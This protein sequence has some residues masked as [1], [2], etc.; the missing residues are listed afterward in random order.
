M[1]VPALVSLGDQDGL[2]H[3]RDASEARCS[4]WPWWPSDLSSANKHQSHP[5][6]VVDLCAH[7]R[8]EP[9]DRG[10]EGGDDTMDSLNQT[11][12]DAAL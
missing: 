5:Y 8:V 9:E 2:P 7:A 4:S 12:A 3:S 6:V 11:M 1:S 10:G